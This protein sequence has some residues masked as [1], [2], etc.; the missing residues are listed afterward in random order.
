MSR[1][2]CEGESDIF[3]QVG[4]GRCG[5][6]WFHEGTQGSPHTYRPGDK[7]SMSG[8]I[9]GG[10]DDISGRGVIHRRTGLSVW[11]VAEGLVPSESARGSQLF[12]ER[13]RCA[14]R[15]TGAFLGECGWCAPQAAPR[16]LSKDG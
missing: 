8:A 2:F 3:Y 15:Y 12:M 14:L 9:R 4:S 13:V 11:L 10:S 7:Y 16:R 1:S 6:L 5:R